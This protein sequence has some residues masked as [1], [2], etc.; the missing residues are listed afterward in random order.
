MMNHY[1]DENGAYT[2][3]AQTNP[4]SLPPNN[5]IRVAPPTQNG[6]WPILNPVGNGWNMIED[7]RGIQG[8]LNG[9]QHTITEL[10]P[11]PEGWSQ[12]APETDD[13][14]SSIEARR[15]QI[16]RRLA[17]IDAETIRPLRAIANESA[18]DYD[19]SRITA[20]DTEAQNLRM[21]LLELTE[22]QQ[23]FYSLSSTGVYHLPSCTYANGNQLTL[24][25]LLAQRP[26]ARPCTRCN[27]Q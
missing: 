8:W 10:G 24:E 26:D 20:L 23:Q 25:Q 13:S 5:A 27:P 18:V 19:L 11:Y 4:G 2:T 1:F 16:L 21:E 6:F 14:S 9:E 22:P 15:T 12:T 3:S 17:V 7:H